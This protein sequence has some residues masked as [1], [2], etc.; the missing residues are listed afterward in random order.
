[1]KNK[2]SKYIISA[3]IIVTA[4]SSCEKDL[5]VYHY[6]DNG[7][8]FYYESAKDTVK[9]FSFVY[10]P[11]TR[12]IDTV[13]V[14]VETVGFIT[15][16]DRDFTFEQV[17]TTGTNALVGKHYVAFDDVSVKS[18]YSIPAGKSQTRV[19]IIV[20]RDASLKTSSVNLLIRVKNNENF[21]IANPSRS[22]TKVIITD[23]LAKPTC[24]AIYADGYFGTY[25]PVKHQFFI[26]Q[27]GK[28]WDDEY[29][30]NVLGFTS[31]STWADGVNSNY[32]S[33]Y[34]VYLAKA[35][36]MKLEAY[37]AARTTK[38]LD[39][40]KEADGTVVAIPAN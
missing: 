29:I 20:K 3:V 24:W 23:Q 30:L 40:L 31:G 1:M 8:N 27:T 37:N 28:K 16:K 14:K 25:G 35:L 21:K 11:T 12:T 39:V 36:S 5:E 34:C 32:D 33:G 13:W 10:G 15:D 22:M 38:G 6:P 4:L 19:P 7:L 18:Y 9:N 2:Y 26:E 17:Q